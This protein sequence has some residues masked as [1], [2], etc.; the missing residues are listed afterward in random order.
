MIVL[1]F[2]PL[3]LGHPEASGYCSQSEWLLF[4]RDTR[5]LRAVSEDLLGGTGKAEDAKL[6]GAGIIPKLSYI[7]ECQ[8]KHLPLGSV[9]RYFSLG[10]QPKWLDVH[11]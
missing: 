2:L 4:G 1:L 8:E 7:R 3:Q 11:P 5:N 9:P 10:I 6:P